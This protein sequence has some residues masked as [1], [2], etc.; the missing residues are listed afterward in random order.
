MA[1]PLTSLLNATAPKHGTETTSANVANNAAPEILPIPTP[2]LKLGER[3][4]VT[5]FS[6]RILI[7]YHPLK[8]WQANRFIG[9][10]LHFAHSMQGHQTSLQMP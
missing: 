10:D 7:P 8:T 1:L 5:V 9:A 6:A 2:L 3:T 4:S